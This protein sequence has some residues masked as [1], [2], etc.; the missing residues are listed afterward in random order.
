VQLEAAVG[1]LGPTFENRLYALP[2]PEGDTGAQLPAAWL[3]VQTNR[4]HGHREHTNFNQTPKIR[5]HGS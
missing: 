2:G 1:V 3:R 5:Q 4:A